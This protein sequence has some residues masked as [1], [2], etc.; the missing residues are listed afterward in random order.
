MRRMEQPAEVHVPDW[1]EVFR[2][3]RP[4]AE[5]VVRGTVMFLVIFAMM[6]VV[7]KRESGGLSLTDVLVVALVAEAAAHGMVGEARG[8]ADSVLLIATIFGWSVAL[9]AIAYRWPRLAPLIKSRA[10]P[11]V[12]DGRVNQRALRR[13][14][15]QHEELMAELRL[16]GISELKDVAR[17]FLEANGQVSVIRADRAEPDN[18]RKPRSTG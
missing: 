16:H 18:P 13:E 14:L 10:S 6:R 15:M 7:G 1:G 8:I 2:L 3:S 17:A 9:D 5:I 11:L 12:V 4:I